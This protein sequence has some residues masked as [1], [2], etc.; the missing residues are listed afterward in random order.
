M[1]Y[2]DVLALLVAYLGPLV[3][4][5]TCHTRVPDPR[6]TA[7]VQL[8]RVGGPRI[9]PVRDQPRVD[10]WCWAATET[11]ASALA[12]TVRTK[13][14]ALA[15]TSTLGV[16]CYRTEEF[17]GPKQDDDEKTGSPR[18]WMTISLLLRADAAVAY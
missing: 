10:F 11:A 16:T 1:A 2:P 14:H 6:P 15:G 8:R 7:W 5:A 13:V 9:V 4:P 3:T 12:D 18:I 17:L